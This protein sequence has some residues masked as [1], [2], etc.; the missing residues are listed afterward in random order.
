MELIRV[1]KR[2]WRV[3][4]LLIVSIMGLCIFQIQNKDDSKV[5]YYYADMVTDFRELM[6]TDG[7]E[8]DYQLAAA[9]V[10]KDVRKDIQDNP[11]REYIQQA[12]QLFHEQVEYIYQYKES[13]ERNILRIS[14]ML[15]SS[16]YAEHNNFGR[17]N[18]IKYGNDMQKVKDIT[19]TLSN[20]A[21]IENLFN[22][23]E[24][25]LLFLLILITIILAFMEEYRNKMV[26]IVRT[27]V[28]GRFTLIF[29]RCGIL[30]LF[31]A[32]LSVAINAL[33]LCIFLYFYGG[34][35]DLI[36]AIQSSQ[37]FSLFPLNIN[38]VQF[39]FLYCACFAFGM[40]AIGIFLYLIM[41][42]MKSDKIAI[43]II[44]AILSVEYILYQNI[45]SNSALCIF[46]YINLFCMILPSS[47]YLKYENWGYNGFATDVSS[48]TSLITFVMIILC[49][50]IVFALYSLKHT[51]QE[52]GWLKKVQE[53]ITTIQQ[54]FFCR[55][56][57]LCMESYKILFLQKGLLIFII[58]VY[59]LLNSQIQRGVDYNNNNSY[60]NEFYEL[61]EGMIPNQKVALYIENEEKNLAELKEAE[62]L[63]SLQRWQLMDRETALIKMKQS[64]VYLKKVNEEQN[65]RAVI[66]DSR[67]YDDIFG[68]RNYTNEEIINLICILAII[69]MVGG[70]FSF[71][72]KS[73]MFI[74]GRTSKKRVKI[75][76]Y[77]IFLV[78][79]VSGSIWGMSLVFHW[80]NICNVYRMNQI[81]AP[82]QSLPAYEHFP[83][84]FNI[85]QY[86]IF[87]QFIRLI[88]FISIGLIVY[89]ISIYVNYIQAIIISMLLLVP[90]LLY[91][92]HITIVQQLSIVITLDVNRSWRLYGN[93][94][95]EY[96][97]YYAIILS[98]GILCNR[99]YCRWVRKGET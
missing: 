43:V 74:L 8:K 50:I 66:M 26:S 56:G 46:K 40:Y 47:S 3:L 81:Y 91:V 71:E 16:L 57:L 27:S 82:L 65:I 68:Q 64:V 7:M 34:K 75:W 17:L 42:W 58:A 23:K 28:K 95:E 49:T 22:F 90:H 89:G 87:C 30:F 14:D 92:F 20:T 84:K 96:L 41:L 54:K 6:Q 10:Y 61:F 76:F 97:L 52:S 99:C 4:I 63:S 36:Y 1:I 25:S 37:M 70:G 53:Y 73:G 51:Q 59:L 33:I 39:F 2:V 48:S 12:D 94:L 77:K 78:L 38:M 29:K 24:L 85:L 86:M 5:Y 67:S 35:A 15:S 44:I 88:L 31:T 9:L 98:A 18:I 13:I 72:K 60:L 80:L 93:H 83:I 79:I 45:P 21:A 32:A 55:T 62:N 11:D 69:L 19:I